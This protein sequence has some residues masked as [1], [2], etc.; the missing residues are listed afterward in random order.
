M[1]FALEYRTLPEYVQRVGV[2]NIYGPK[3][4]RI[5]EEMGYATKRRPEM[6]GLSFE[7]APYVYWYSYD[8]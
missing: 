3:T 4:L 7:K 5:L 2:E 8:E 6:V 1:S